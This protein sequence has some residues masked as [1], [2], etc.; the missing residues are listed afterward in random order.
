MTEIV[1]S[2]P[3]YGDISI[4]SYDHG[5]CC[6]IKKNIVW[7]Q[8]ILDLIVKILKR[9]EKTFIDVGAF[10]GSHSIGVS[11]LVPRTRIVAFEPTTLAFRCLQENAKRAFSSNS[12]I[13]NLALSDK[14]GRGFMVYNKDGNPGGSKLKPDPP[15][16]LFEDDGFNVPVDVKT[17]DS[18]NIQNVSLIKIDVEGNEDNVLLGTVKTIKKWKPVMIVRIQGGVTYLTAS[19]GQK[20]CIEKSIAL[21]ESLKYKVQL[22]H[23]HDYLCTPL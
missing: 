3:L 12:E 15:N 22:I 5:I 11:K 13:H 2:H 16:N 21:I 6:H 19:P 20:I 1:T 18:F 7:E 10:I 23:F 8:H 4:I 17:L 14:D 9:D